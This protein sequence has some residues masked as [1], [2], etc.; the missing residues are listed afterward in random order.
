MSIWTRSS[1]V[2]DVATLWLS[3]RCGAEE[4]FYFL[5]RKLLTLAGRG[6]DWR[7]VNGR[8]SGGPTFLLSYANALLSVMLR[9]RHNKSTGPA[10]VAPFQW[11]EMLTTSSVCVFNRANVRSSMSRALPSPTGGTWPHRLQRAVTKQKQRL[12]SGQHTRPQ[13]NKSILWGTL[14]QRTAQMAL[15]QPCRLRRRSVGPDTTRVSAVSSK[16][17]NNHRMA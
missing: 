9:C 5:E 2:N 3:G 6:R 8:R 4:F 12:Q 15:V 17:N 7:R 11:P 1:Q 10:E 13:H 16:N 14:K